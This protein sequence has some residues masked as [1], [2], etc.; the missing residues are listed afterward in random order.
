MR[1]S[2]QGASIPVTGI[3]SDAIPFSWA[4]AKAPDLIEERSR[5]TER[6]MK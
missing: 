3:L 6:E 1:V 4:L 5:E 2:R